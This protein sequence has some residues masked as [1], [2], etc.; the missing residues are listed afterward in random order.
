MVGLHRTRPAPAV[1][2]HALS[3]GIRGVDT[4]YNY[5]GGWSHALLRAAAGPR[6]PELVISTKV[7]YFPTRTGPAR[8]TLAPAALAR[9]VEQS[10]AALD[11]TPSVVFLHNPEHTLAALPAARAGER[12][13]AA[14]RA[15]REASDAGYCHGWGVSCWSAAALLPAIRHLPESLPPMSAVMVR[16]GLS[17]PAVELAAVEHLIAGL[18][19]P[20]ARVWGM[21]PFG[22]GTTASTAWTPAVTAPFLANPAAVSPHQGALR[23]AFELPPVGRL[24]VGVR[25]PEQLHALHAARSLPIRRDRIAAYRRLLASRAASAGQRGE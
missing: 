18:G 12:L 14:C 8:H 13:L 7:G 17:V 19:M 9:L 5:Q 3:L 15:L 23:V 16:A 1:L 2:D 22:G 21:A 20:R 25:G 24:A 10:A 11:T 6:M 4:A